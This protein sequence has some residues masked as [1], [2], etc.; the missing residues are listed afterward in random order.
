MTVETAI[1]DIDN[2]GVGKKV[3]TQYEPHTISIVG[4]NAL[5]VN[6]NK[7]KSKS[8]DFLETDKGKELMNKVNK[9]KALDKAKPEDELTDEEREALKLEQ[10]K[11]G[12]VEGDVE[13]PVV[14]TDPEKPVV[15]T[16]TDEDPEDAPKVDPEAPEGDVAPVV[17]DEPV[18]EDTLVIE[19]TPVVIEDEPVIEDTPVIEDVPVIEIGDGDSTDKA[20]SFTSSEMITAQTD[21]LKGVHTLVDKIHKAIPDASL[22]E[23]TD[24]V[25]SSI[26]K[27]EDAIWSAENSEWNDIYDEVSA[28]VSGRVNKAKALKISEDGSL[29]QKLK[30]LEAID[31]AL[32]I[33]F[34][35][36]MDEN[37]INKAKALD[38]ENETK[39]VIRAKALEQGAVD[40][41]RIATDGNTTE[42]IVDAMTSLAISD[43]ATHTVIA[44]AL[45]TASA[46]TM[47]G[48]LFKDMGSSAD[49][50][51]LSEPEYVMSKAKSLVD[52]NGGNLA[53]AK[54]TVR[55][56]E[57]YIALYK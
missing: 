11:E 18:I 10:A 19:D 36:Q 25:Y 42:Q 8:D 41:K 38:A 52:E 48:E 47:G 32:A 23:I 46:I 6:I 12:D 39:A 21:I 55:Q 27:V 53:A 57:D 51:Q 17:V 24:M 7:V 26:W 40:F 33:V 1:L 2:Q 13:A 15:D 34:K 16:S 45:A 31:P 35:A 56:T 3:L 30:S 54:A 9:A 20:K 49:A 37:A 4:V 14:D 5:G 43:K 50:I 22:W 44:K 28:E 29:E